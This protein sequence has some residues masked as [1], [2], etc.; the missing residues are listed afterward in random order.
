MSYNMLGDSM[1]IETKHN[2]IILFLPKNIISDICFDDLKAVEAYFKKIIINLR[3]YYNIKLFGCY[4]VYL[5]VDKIY[6]IIMEMEKIDDNLFLDDLIDM[7]I[8]INMDS[9]ILYKVSDYEFMKNIGDKKYYYQN[10]FYCTIDE[11][12]EIKLLP[13]L[14]Y[15]E[16]IY[17]D[18]AGAI[19]N[20][21]QKIK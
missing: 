3:K 10:N 11:M 1:K 18:E 5:Y 20:K 12:D 4:N 14:E 7:K 2:K 8:F 6:G 16:I 21:A 19:I 9:P 13:F 17:G 15:C